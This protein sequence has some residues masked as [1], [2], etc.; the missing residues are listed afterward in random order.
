M[1][2]APPQAVVALFNSLTQAPK[3]HVTELI[4]ALKA[5]PQCNQSSTDTETTTM[6]APAAVKKS[7]SN[8]NKASTKGPKRPL[9]SWMAYRSKLLVNL[10]AHLAFLLTFHRVLQQDA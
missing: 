7:R 1:A 2:T 10:A 8:K 3:E 4:K 5:L 6:T 9:N